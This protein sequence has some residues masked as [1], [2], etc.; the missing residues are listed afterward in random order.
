VENEYCLTL[1]PEHNAFIIQYFSNREL[2]VRFLLEDSHRSA[3]IEVVHITRRSILHGS[4]L[5]YFT[6]IIFT[7]SRRLF[8][9]KNII[10]RWCSASVIL[11]VSLHM[12]SFTYY[13]FTRL[14]YVITFHCIRVSK[15][16]LISYINDQAAGKRWVF[17]VQ[18]TDDKTYN[19]AYTTKYWHNY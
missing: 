6:E 5:C 7:I 8:T 14:F 2:T 10:R 9:M 15:T 12:F 19:I 11:T 3:V 18:N 4:P 13:I 1:K 16:A 17:N